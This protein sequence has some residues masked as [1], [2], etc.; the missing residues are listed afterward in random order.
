MAKST[1]NLGL[2]RALGTLMPAPKRASQE[3]VIYP[4]P[5]SKRQLLRRG[6]NQTLILSLA[7]QPDIPKAIDEVSIHKRAFRA[8]QSSLD[9]RHRRRNARTLFAMNN[10]ALRGHAI[11]VDDVITTGATVSAIAEK[12]RRHGV[13]KV[14]VL[15]LSAV[16]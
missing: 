1:G 4:V 11:I 9:G 5:V 8:R 12:L 13:R 7:I 16:P 15:A 14:D 6:F 2:M 10:T 3:T